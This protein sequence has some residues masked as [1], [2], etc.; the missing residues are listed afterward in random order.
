MAT[1]KIDAAGLSCPQPVL[2][3]AAKAPEMKAGDVIEV[4][5]DCPT[6]ERDVKTWCDRVGKTFLSIE[7]LGTGKKLIRVQF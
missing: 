5:G 2:K 6:F 4:I 7:E 1:V 3:I